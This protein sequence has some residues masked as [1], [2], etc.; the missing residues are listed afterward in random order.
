MAAGG[1]GRKPA[2]PRRIGGRIA[3][4]IGRSGSRRPA[5]QPTEAAGADADG[6]GNALDDA[7]RLRDE[8]SWYAL[9]LLSA[10]FAIPAALA[11]IAFVLVVNE[12]TKLAW[13]TLPAS[14]GIPRAVLVVGL[15][16]LGG[17]LVGLIV[18]YMPGGAGPAPAAGHGIGGVE[19]RLARGGREPRPRGAASQD[20]L[21]ARE[22]PHR[23]A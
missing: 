3:P 4:A 2:T 19:R 18:R 21:R 22:R 20:H 23:A 7:A 11:T 9:L 1:T 5:P 6:G 10:V 14:L 12:G 13:E 16:T 17:L 15:P 8:K